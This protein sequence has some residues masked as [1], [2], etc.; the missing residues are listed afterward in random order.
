MKYT[1]NP[2]VFGSSFSFPAS[3]VDNCLKIATETEIKVILYFF[4]HFAEGVIIDNCAAV[5]DISKSEVTAALSFWKKYDVI[6]AC[7]DEDVKTSFT[8]RAVVKNERPTRVDVAKRGSEDK[9][10]AM[11]LNEAQLKFGRSLKTNESSTFLYIYEDLGLDLSVCLYLLQYA[12]NQGKTNIRFIEKTAVNWVNLG[13]KTISDA[14]KIVINELN[15]NLAWK[16]CQKAFGIEQR[17]AS[18]KELEC[19]LKWF[20]EWKL[21]EDYLNLAYNVCVDTKSKFIF[22]YCAKIIENWHNS[23][24]NSKEDVEDYLSKHSSGKD[25]ENNYAGYDI[26]LYEKMLENCD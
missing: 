16:R 17:K 11:I 22:S 19:S 25:E 21:D 24:L 4:R 8:K 20:D 14:E 3:V 26:E 6:T 1:I 13:V 23:G 18:P 5:L 10:F 9:N 2:V 12:V 7:D 15:S